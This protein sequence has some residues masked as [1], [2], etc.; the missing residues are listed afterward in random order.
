MSRTK[1]MTKLALWLFYL[2]NYA[3]HKNFTESFK[4]HDNNINRIKSA[5]QNVTA[6]LQLVFTRKGRLSNYEWKLAVHKLLLLH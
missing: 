3:S 2:Y 5:K 1:L 4:N 6:S